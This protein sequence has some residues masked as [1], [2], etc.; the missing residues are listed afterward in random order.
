MIQIP[1]LRQ[2][3]EPPPVIDPAN[4]NSATAE[5][6]AKTLQRAM[7]PAE[8]LKDIDL[9]SREDVVGPWFKQ[10]DLG[11]IY[12]PRG[13]GKTWLAL[14]LARKIAEG[15]RVACWP[16]ARPRR[17]LYVDGEMPLDGLRER[18]AALASA[19]AG[20]RMNYLQHEEL[21]HLCGGSLNLAHPTFQNAI[22][23]LCEKE[24]IDVLFLD[25][26]SCL[27]SGMNENDADG[28]DKVL[29]WLL[30]LRR[31][32]VSVV[33]VAHAGRNGFMRG[34]SRREDAAFWMLQLTP[35]EKSEEEEE[36]GG[37]RFVSRFDKNRNATDND[38]PP[39][40]FTFRR[41]E[42][43]TAEVLWKHVGALE[44]FRYLVEHG[45]T[46]ASQIA[47]EMGV[48]AARVSALAKKA[49]K[50]GWLRKN[51]RDY[52]F[53]KPV[54]V[55]TVPPEV[56]A[57]PR[58]TGM[59]CLRPFQRREWNRHVAKVRKRCPHMPPPPH[60]RTSR[61]FRRCS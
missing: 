58:L 50:E 29:P 37:A 51:G 7:R 30:D 48:S 53:V 33:F 49:M 19:D 32:R 31:R 24:K 41:G 46:T 28:W 17:V 35:P 1:T 56:A 23:I 13:L 36:A 55:A 27:F 54:R 20:G 61:R 8:E 57:S 2:L 18:D 40:E 43:G 3:A 6:W 15:G 25:N 10:G 45:L 44:K 42:N 60:S 16:A 26:L 52:E 39:I 5:E 22:K 4:I 12:G 11:F 38:C 14:Y 47:E 59:R 9:P 21:F 34:T